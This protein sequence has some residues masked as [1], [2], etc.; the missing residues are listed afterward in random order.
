VV[1]AVDEVDVAEVA[2]EICTPPEAEEVGG[3]LEAGPPEEEEGVEDDKVGWE[4]EGALEP[5][6]GAAAEEGLSEGWGWDVRPM[7]ELLL[8]EET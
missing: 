5:E 4:E 3:P 7:D 6:A 8:E 2:P 1:L